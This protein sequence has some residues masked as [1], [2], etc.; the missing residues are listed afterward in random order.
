M[1]L[2]VRIL[3]F[4]AERFSTYIG[5]SRRIWTSNPGRHPVLLNKMSVQGVLYD[6][7]S[8]DELGEAHRLEVIG[9]LPSPPSLLFVLTWTFVPG[10]PPDE[11]ASLETFK[12][13]SFHRVICIP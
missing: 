4:C 2:R 1:S 7:V 11:A 10:F 9:D 13:I 3:S 8:A 5:V 12:Y 6:W